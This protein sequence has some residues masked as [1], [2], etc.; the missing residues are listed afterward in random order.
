[1][2]ATGGFSLS[3]E[4]L[5]VFAPR[6]RDALPIGGAGNVGDGLRMGWALGADVRDMGF[7]KGTFGTHPRGTTTRNHALLL[8]FYKGAIVV[9]TAGPF[10]R[11]GTPP[12][13]SANGA[14]ARLAAIG[15]SGWTRPSRVS[16]P[17]PTRRSRRPR[18]SPRS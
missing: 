10:A 2:L 5:D 12:S 11:H 7:I 17:R 14:T 9:N 16:S 6:Q 8:A 18:R 4:L 13:R 15:V 3:P 1:M